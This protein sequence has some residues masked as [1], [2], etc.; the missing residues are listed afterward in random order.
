MDTPRQLFVT[1]NEAKQLLRV[2]HTRIYQLI[3]AGHIEKVKLGS[4]TLIPCDS[5]DRYVASLRKAAA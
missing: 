3:N 1:I 5:L 2:G 4:K